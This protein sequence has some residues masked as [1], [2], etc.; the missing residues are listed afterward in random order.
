MFALTIKSIAN[1]AKGKYF[2]PEELLKAVPAGI[3]TDSR[4]V[5][6]GFVYAA[7]KGEKTDGHNYIK[8]SVK[9]GAICAIAEHEP[10]PGEGDF[11]DCPYI[12]VKDTGDALRDIAELFRLHI[13]AKVI[14]ITG[15]VGKTSTKETIASVLSQRFKIHKTEGNFNNQLGVPLTLFGTEEDD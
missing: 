4:K 1:A 11:S 12:L 10:M 15:S 6:K 9:S 14:G 2:G 7:I 3:V 5:E 8:G 13:D